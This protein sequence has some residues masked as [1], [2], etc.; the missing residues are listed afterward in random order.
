MNIK[1]RKTIPQLG[2]EY[3]KSLVAWPSHPWTKSTLTIGEHGIIT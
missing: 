1:L 2:I 3:Y